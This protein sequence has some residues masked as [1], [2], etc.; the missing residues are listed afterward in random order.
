MFPFFVTCSVSS[1]ILTTISLSVSFSTTVIFL[2]STSTLVITPSSSSARTSGDDE[3]HRHDTGGQREQELAAVL[4]GSLSSKPNAPPP[5][6][7]PPAFPLGA[8]HTSGPRLGWDR[9][10]INTEMAPR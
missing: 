9:A 7:G 5:K 1:V 10:I 3:A 2:P 6:R 8:A 4:H